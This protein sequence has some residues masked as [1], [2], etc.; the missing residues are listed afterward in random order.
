MFR[1]AEEV[2]AGALA[3]CGA[4]AAACAAAH[5]ALGIRACFPAAYGTLGL[6][7]ASAWGPLRSGAVP[8]LLRRF[9]AVPLSVYSECGLLA[10][11]AAGDAV[12]ACRTGRSHLLEG[13]RQLH[14][15]PRAVSVLLTVFFSTHLGSTNVNVTTSYRRPSCR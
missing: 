9:S 1:L 11:L 3:P 12:A 2:A 15:A 10:G 13:L 5:L 8:R 4:D 14:I 7:P 6:V